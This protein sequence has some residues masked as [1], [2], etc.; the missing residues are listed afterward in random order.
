MSHAALHVVPRARID[1]SVTGAAPAHTPRNRIISLLPADEAARLVPMLEQVHATLGE[2]LA[3][4]GACMEWVYFPESGIASVVNVTDSGLVEV[5]TVGNEGMVGLCALLDADP[6]P[7]RTLW[8]VQGMS[9]RMTRANLSASFL[10]LP[11]FRALLLRY[12]HAFLV[13]VAQTA[14]CNRKHH[15]DQRC[16]RWLLMTHD[17]VATNTFGL[18]QRLLGVMLGVH[19]PAVTLSAQALQRAGLITYTRGSITIIDRAGLEAA[20]CE[21]HGIVRDHFTRFLGPGP[22]HAA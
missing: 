1:R 18:T 2:V 14:S 8:Q 4:P 10:E 22:A 19:R 11:T 15:I 9:L 3:E 13:Q 20:S 6:M 21:C 17:R 12:A 16:A 5:G 7:S